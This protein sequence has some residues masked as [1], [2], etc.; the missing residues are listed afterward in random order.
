MGD[1][2]LSM[3]RQPLPQDGKRWASNL[4]EKQKNAIAVDASNQHK[5]Q[6]YQQ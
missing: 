6:A 3:V 4:C 2:G 5:K 1:Q